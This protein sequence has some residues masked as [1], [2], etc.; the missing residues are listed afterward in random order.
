MQTQSL[1]DLLRKIREKADFTLEDLSDETHIKLEYLEALEDNDFEALPAATFVKAY[2]RN[3]AR[4]FDVDEKPLFAILR[5]DYE[6]SVKG[7][8][9]RRELLQPKLKR[10][11]LWSP[12]QLVF[13]AAATV[14][15]VFFSYAAW[16]WYQL[17]RPPAL[18]LT[19]PLENEAVS[20]RVFF[21][22]NTKPDAILTI[23]SMPVALQGDGSFSTE[24]YLPQDGINTVTIRAT[25]KNGKST[26][27]QRNVQVEF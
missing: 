11:T 3:Y 15:L 25:D 12:I 7:Q 13:L 10:K 9:I 2:I 23:N 18:Y 16:Q 19:S 17:S 8:L 20:S 14:F 5:R 22:G 6:E 21:Q 4:V 27:L 1:G 24:L 26:V